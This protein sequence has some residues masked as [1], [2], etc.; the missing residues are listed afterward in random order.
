MGASPVSAGP[1]L[2]KEIAVSV[3]IPTFNRSRLLEEVIESLWNQTLDPCR[4]EIIIVDDASTDDT[5]EV[6]ERLRERSP[7]RLVHHRLTVHHGPARARNEAVRMAHGDIIAFTDS[8]CRADREWL[9]KGLSA[10]GDGIAF[11]TGSV[12]NKPEQP[13]RFFSGANTPLVQE[14]ASYPTC[15]AF[16][17]RSVFLDLDGFDETLS[18]RAFLN[19]AMECADTDLAWR[20]KKRGYRNV[21]VPD[22]VIYHEVS[23]KS[24][25]NWLLDP[26]RLFVV[27]ALVRRHPQL[28]DILLHGR[29]LFFKENVLL[30]LA[31]L[32][33]VLGLTVQWMFLAL[34]LVYPLWVAF[35]ALRENLALSKLPKLAV[36]ALLLEARQGVICIALIYGSI[37]FRTL[38]L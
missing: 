37:R 4:Y 25:W 26:V 5:A 9:A 15:N 17:R 22:L 38:V 23:Q 11:V 16:Y 30:Y 19:R 27:P 10:F 28:R 6:I 12:L 35:F 1:P 13:V 7:C 24:P 8:D 2:E 20:I 14:H 32:G 18:Y 34:A 36:Q 31:I 21:F 29:V 3:V 33:V